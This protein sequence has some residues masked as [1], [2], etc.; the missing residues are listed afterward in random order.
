MT[1][2]PLVK[3]AGNDLLEREEPLRRLAEAFA[4]SAAGQGRIIALGAEAGAGKTALIER[5]IA[6]HAQIARTYWGACE[7]LSTPEILLPLRDIARASGNAFAVGG[8]PISAFEGLLRLLSGGSKCPV[9]VVEDIHWADTATLD[10]IRFIG[11]RI[12]RIR[13]L[14]LITYRDEEVDVRS[15]LRTLL[16]ELPAGSVE[17]MSLAPLSQGAVS[18]LAARQGR[19][20]AQL[21]AVTAGN[22]FLVTE[23]LAVD[24]DLPSD[25]VRDATLARASRLSEEA[26]AVLD[27]V[28]IFPRHA[29][30]ALIA[31]LVKY[32]I[33]DGLD[34]CIDK[35]ML[36]LDGAILRFRHEL[37][38]RAIEVSIP[39]TLQRAMHQKVVDVLRHRS[40]ARPNEIA[41]HAERAGDIASLLL[42]AQLAGEA[43][44]RA[45]AS[46]EAAAHFET[47]LRHRDGL[48]PELVVDVL[49]LHAEQAYLAGGAD[50]AMISMAEAASL[51]RR[52][53]NML[54]LGRNLTRLTRFAWMCGRRAEAE[55]FVR[56]SIAV[57]ETAPPGPELAWAYSHQSQLDMLAS[58][59]DSAIVWGE[60]AL[61]LARR[62]GEQ[63]IIVH[64]LGNVGSA[65]VDHLRSGKCPQLEQSFELAVA[66]R[67]H[68]HVERAS[69]NLT[70]TY[71]WR[72][73]Y[74]VSLSWIAR[75]VDYATALEL[76][77]WEGYLRGWR[78][79][80][81]LDRGQWDEAEDEAREICSRVFSADVYRFPALIALA[82]LR[83]RRGDQDA[84]T[85]LE[86]AQRLAEVMM[87][88]Q[89][90]VYVAI[91]LAEGEWLETAPPGETA[92]RRLLREVHE[93]ARERKA[94][95]AIEDTALWLHALGESVT[96]TE[97]FAAPFR[98]H[99]QGQWREAA[100][101]WKALGRP[102]DEA[103]AL[104]YGDESA[105]RQALEIFDRLGAVPAA[106]RMRRQLR[107]KGAR[108][109]PRGPI[110]PTRANLAG[111]TRR[112]TQVLELLD[113][114][115]SNTEI[116]THLCIAPKTAEHHV[117]AIMARFDSPSRK[118]ATDTARKLGL[119]GRPKIRGLPREN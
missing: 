7:N 59:M 54:A 21:F 111:L 115:L 63:E 61:E 10:L 18:V 107:S 39:P 34:E 29:E 96:G 85:P 68:D 32:S 2:I 42:Y 20:G 11:R 87:E 91:T 84:D 30:T 118:A 69:C 38:R 89:R 70:C 52:A 86:T 31:E 55:N 99:V 60:R 48:K 77:H 3:Q 101:G 24:G 81:K 103:L 102:Y 40:D 104:S 17:R 114:G 98:E 14:L 51:R 58:R 110:A 75:G 1:G 76:N 9:L 25:S 74:Q 15:P 83:I 117:A 112:Q 67:F 36:S 113:D 109:V 27:A 66:N 8:D 65:T 47:M 73:D 88:L 108:A 92:G 26:S 16:G 97:S 19:N 79:M 45:A 33:D 44:V 28:S 80:I 4:R 6:D 100:T 90:S 53:G 22:P 82:R 106:T 95:W 116:A 23:A 56:E 71:F 41:H 13:A 72:R 43:A 57:L 5:F 49:E 78:A 46:R 64:A 50:R 35:G 105:Q 93:L 94:L 119:L 12:A 37:A 62:L